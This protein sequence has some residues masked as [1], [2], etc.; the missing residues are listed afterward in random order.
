M[1]HLKEKTHMRLGSIFA[2]VLLTCL[3]GVPMIAFAN[4]HAGAASGGQNARRVTIPAG[5]R[6]LVRTNDAIDSSRSRAGFRFT[7]TLET[8]LQLDNVTVAPRGTVVHG[9][10]TDAQSAGRMSGGANLTLE[11]TDIIINGTA[12]P[13][14][15][16]SFEMHGQG[17]GGSTT[18][19]VAGGAGLGALV[20][21]IAG[22]GRGAAIG[23]A[24]GGGTGVALSAARSGEQIS[25]PR[26]SLLE[27]RLAQPASLPTAR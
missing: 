21:G 7:A 10:L 17:Q 16:N 19:R 6:I 24:A 14:M 18:R 26:E 13:I 23:A 4:F 11:L 22:G 15:T 20:G 9:Q 8:N 5:T 2:A 12:N 1:K 27:F 25:V 3:V